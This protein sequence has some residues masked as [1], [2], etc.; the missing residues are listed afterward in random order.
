MNVKFLNV[1]DALENMID[2]GRA[3]FESDINS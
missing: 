1:V 3:I 2:V